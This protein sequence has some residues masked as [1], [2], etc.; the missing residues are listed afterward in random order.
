MVRRGENQ[1]APADDAALT[2]PAA[3]DG[4]ERTV[5]DMRAMAEDRRKRGFDTYTLAS[6][7]TGTIAPNE[8][9]P[10]DDRFGLSHLIP[11]DELEEF[12]EFYQ[13]GEYTDTGVYQVTDSGNTL[14]VTEHIDHDNE[15][16]IYIAGAFRIVDAAALVRAAMDRGY[17]HT[18]VRTL[19]NE[20]HGTFKHDDPSAFFPDPQLYY[21]YDPNY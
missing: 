14:M 20:I 18:Y 6:G 16:I 13:N 17:L 3:K 7:N 11:D 10:D 9:G 19:D 12:E 2:D 15:R 21:S 5:E 1:Q 8:G 4:W